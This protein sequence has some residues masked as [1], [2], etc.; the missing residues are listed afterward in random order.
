M[1]AAPVIAAVALGSN[2]GDRA[3]HIQSAFAA[4][5]ALPST[6]LVARSA[7][8][9]TDPVGPGPQGRYLNAG[10]IL[11]TSLP[12][13]DLL[14]RLLAIEA[15]RG[16]VR[17]PAE[18]WGPRTLDLDLLLYGDLVLDEPGLEIPHPRLHERRFVLEPLVS[19]APDLRH[20]LLGRT[21]RELLADLP[22]GS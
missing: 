18:R 15:S 4:L 1:N 12:P 8:I 5:G 3:A 19:I 21:M 7:T 22:P 6:R 16:R 11:S 9:E 13:R 20:P 17:N 10:A 14:D 2:V